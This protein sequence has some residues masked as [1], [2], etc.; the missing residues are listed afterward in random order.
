MAI[1]KEIK[2]G[3]VNVVG[4]DKTIEVATDTILKEDGIVLSQ[5]RHRKTLYPT[6][7]SGEATDISNE[8]DE[9]KT[10]AETVWTDEVKAA[11]AEK[12]RLQEEDSKT[13]Q[14]PENVGKP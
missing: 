7:S 11:W 1:T 2:I 6:T 5:T 3:S 13:R 8:P 10:I 12:M 14:L 9:V 4:D